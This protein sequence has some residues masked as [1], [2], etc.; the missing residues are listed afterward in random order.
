[1]T[2]IGKGGA[3]TPDLWAFPQ[4]GGLGGMALFEGSLL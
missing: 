3:E 1:M 4:L 2:E